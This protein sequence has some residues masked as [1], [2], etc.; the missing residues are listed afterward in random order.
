MEKRL[1]NM[2]WEQ[3]SRQYPL[4]MCHFLVEDIKTNQGKTHCVFKLVAQIDARISVSFHYIELFMS[5]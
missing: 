1:C 5:S 4:S 2:S 3:Q